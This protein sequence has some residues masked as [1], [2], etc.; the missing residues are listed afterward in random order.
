MI[1]VLFFVI[2]ITFVLMHLA[3]GGP[4]DREG[5]QLTPQVINNLNIKYGLDKPL[6]QQFL[7]YIWGVVHFDFGDSL[8]SPGQHVSQRVLESWPYT[9]TLGAVTFLLLVPLGIGLGVVAALRQNSVADYAAL[10]LATAAASTPN[11]VIGIF[12]IIFLA[13]GMN[14]LTGG[15]FYLPTGGMPQ[16]FNPFQVELIMPVITL[17]ALPTAY[18]ARLTR[19][20]TLDTLRQDFVRTAWAKGLKARLVVMR[21]VLKNSLI[22][23]VTALG[24]TFAFLVTGSFIV[25]TLF[26]IPGI[27][28]SFVTSISGRDYTMILGTT[29]LFAVLIAVVNLIVDVLYVFIDPRVRLSD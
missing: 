26:S 1:P 22:P 18:I 25:E 20:S 19:S 29:I 8:R 28:R 10:G 14:R 3:P 13:L 16:P 2:V 7:T 17:G 5:K 4:W 12:L 11:F 23:V 27:G 21:H 15:T 24:P 6:P 9:F